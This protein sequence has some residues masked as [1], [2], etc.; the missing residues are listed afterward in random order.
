[1]LFVWRDWN[2]CSVV[3]RGGETTA[4]SFRLIWFREVVLMGSFFLEPLS[5]GISL[6]WFVGLEGIF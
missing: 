5:Y 6:L 1:V 4:V 3:C 2:G